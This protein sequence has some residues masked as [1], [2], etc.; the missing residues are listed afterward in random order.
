MIPKLVSPNSPN[1]ENPRLP[2]PN[3][4]YFKI[5]K[6]VFQIHLTSRFQ[7]SLHLT[8]SLSRFHSS[9][10]LITQLNEMFFPLS[11]FS[12]NWNESK[13]RPKTPIS[14]DFFALASLVAHH[15]AKTETFLKGLTQT[16]QKALQ[17]PRD[18]VGSLVNLNF[19]ELEVGKMAPKKVQLY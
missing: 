13:W 3:S 8:H 7:N 11:N 4:S 19:R 14:V 9:L 18:L 17:Y 12:G 6:L 1:I 16:H 15:C 2:S 10:H 5:L